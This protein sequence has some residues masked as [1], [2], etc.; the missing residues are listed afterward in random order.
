MMTHDN[1]GTK[2]GDSSPNVMDDTAFDLRARAELA[3]AYDPGEP[4]A[5]LLR[6]TV[7]YA[8]AGV[9][10]ML[11]ALLIGSTVTGGVFA[12]RPP[13]L[14]RG[15]IEHEYYERTLRGS[16]MPESELARHL[17][18]PVQEKLPGYTQLMRP[19]EID[20]LRAYHL[21]TFFEKGGIVTVMSFEQPQQIP[22]GQGWWGNTYWKVLRSREG[23]PLVLIAEKKQA[24][25][26]ASKAL[27]RPDA[28]S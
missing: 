19:C 4:P 26:A 22:D 21:T 1:P 12:M 8:R 15:A 10:R 14:V 3:L 23:R 27:G 20:G 13:Q 24:L 9:R 25:A 6:H 7:W 11:A 18:M 5:H 28:A 17:D 16:F 2:A